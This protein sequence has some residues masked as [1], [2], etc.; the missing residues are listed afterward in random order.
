MIHKK[1]D[2]RCCFLSERSSGSLYQSIAPWKYSYFEYKTPIPVLLTYGVVALVF[3]V[4]SKR[5]VSSIERRAKSRYIR[6]KLKDAFESGILCE[7]SEKRRRKAC[8]KSENSFDGVDILWREQ[9]GFIQVCA[10]QGRY[11]CLWDELR[12]TIRNYTSSP[13]NDRL[14]SAPDCRKSSK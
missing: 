5:V 11:A 9:S 6:V 8:E 10:G 2:V 14:K 7:R 4:Q 3:T 12:R 1:L 13:I